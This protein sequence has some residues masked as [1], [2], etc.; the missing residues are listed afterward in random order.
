M[1]CMTLFI[2]SVGG[3]GSSAKFRLLIGCDWNSS[4]ACLLSYLFKVFY[5]SQPW[6]LHISDIFGVVSWEFNPKINCYPTFLGKMCLRKHLMCFWVCPITVGQICIY[7][8]QD[9]RSKWLCIT[10]HAHISGFPVLL[11]DHPVFWAAEIFRLPW[12]I[13]GFRQSSWLISFTC[14]MSDLFN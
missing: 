5:I 14:L 12:N 4:S 2:T 10:A 13:K 3:S 11:L 9:S 1:P 8:A 6:L 7:M